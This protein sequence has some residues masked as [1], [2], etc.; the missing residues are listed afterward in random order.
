MSHCKSN[1]LV[2]KDN[3]KKPVFLIRCLAY[4]TKWL[5][6][7][8]WWEAD[9]LWEEAE[10]EEEEKEEEEEGMYI[11]TRISTDLSDVFLK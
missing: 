4:Y 1:T 11:L 6:L 7:Q 9:F 8:V 2:K 5:Q 10:G 3:N